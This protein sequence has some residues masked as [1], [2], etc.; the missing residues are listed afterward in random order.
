M[1]MRLCLITS[2]GLMNLARFQVMY[3]GNGTSVTKLIDL[4][5]FYILFHQV[6]YKVYIQMHSWTTKLSSKC[7]QLVLVIRC[8]L[9]EVADAKERLEKTLVDVN[10]AAVKDAKEEDSLALADKPYTRTMYASNLCKHSV[11]LFV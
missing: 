7:F 4:L 5:C 8:M 6:A 2:H 10:T 11:W 9:Q 3:D 1:C